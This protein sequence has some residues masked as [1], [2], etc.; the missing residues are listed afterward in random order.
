MEDSYFIPTAALI[1]QKVLMSAVYFDHRPS[2]GFYFIIIESGT[3][4]ELVK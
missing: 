4:I 2:M 3:E 1:A